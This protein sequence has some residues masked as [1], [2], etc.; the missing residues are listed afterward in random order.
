MKRRAKRA[1]I[2]MIFLLV[3]QSVV[4]GIAPI[5]M[6]YAEENKNDTFFDFESISEGSFSEED[7]GWLLHIDWSLADYDL[8]DVNQPV[9]FNSPVAL[10]EQEGTISS[11]GEE[12]E[13]ASF[14]T[15]EDIIRVTFNESALEHSEAEGTLKLQLPLE[16]E[17]EVVEREETTEEAVEEGS[18]EEGTGEAVEEEVAEE[19]G[20]EEAVEEEAAEEEEGTEEAVEEEA[21]EEE[22]TEEAVEEEAAEEEGTEEAVEEEA[23]E[24]EGTEEAVEEE[25]AEE[26][27]TEEAVEEEA[28]EEENIAPSAASEVGPQAELGNIFTFE[29]FRLDG[30]N[31]EDGHEVDF[32]GTYEVQYSWETDE[33]IQAGDTASMP[34]PDVFLHWVNTPDQPIMVE[35]TQVGTFTINDGELIFT[36]DENIEDQS[37]QNGYV[38][39]QLNF[40]REI[41]TEEWEQEIDFDGD[42]ERDLTVQVTPTEVNTDLDK[43]GR[44]DSPVN[45]KEVYWT[46]NIVNGADEAIENG[47]LAD[48][49]P[50]GLGEARDFEV[51]EIT[52]D[53]DGN[54]IVGNPIDD[55]NAPT[56]TGDGFEMT[57]DSI[58]GRSGYQVNYTTSIEDINVA[59]FTNDATFVSD[60]IDL[61]AQATVSGGERSNPIQKEGNRVDSESGDQI[62][63]TIIVNENGMSIDDARVEDQLPDGLKIVPGSINISLNGGDS[64]IEADDFPIELGQVSPDQTYTITYLT[65]INWSEVNEGEYQENNGF[66]NTAILFDGDEELNDDDATVQFDRGPILEKV[67]AGNIDYENRTV[68]WKVTV[69]KAKHLLGDVTVTDQLP[70]GLTLTNITITGENGNEF[71]GATHDEEDGLLTIDL[72]DVGTETITIEYTTSI[73]NFNNADAFTNTVGMEGDGV[74]EGGEDR[75]ATIRPHANTYQKSFDGIN[76]NEKTINWRLNVDPTRE[77]INEGFTI[78]DTFTNDG[79]ILLP[80]T[81]EITLGNENLVSGEDYTLAPIEGGYQ[82]GFTIVFN[83]EIEKA[84]L[85]VN[86]TTSYDEQFVDEDVNSLIPHSNEDEAG[87]YR[88]HA[89]FEGTTE[90]NREINEEDDASQRVI[91]NAWNS[92]F[93]EGNL[94]DSDSWSDASDR[95]IAW[96]VYFNYHQHNLGENVSVTDT[97]GY[98]GEIIEDSIT[99]SVYEVDAGGNT[100]ITDTELTL[101]DDYTVEVEG[102]ELTVNFNGEVTERYVIQFETRVPDI[103]EENYV[104]HA[105]VT[106]EEGEYPYSSS[107][108]YDRWDNVLNKEV[109][110]DVSEVYIGEELEWKITANESLSRISD[111]TL[112]DTIS[113]GLSF[114]EDSLT[115]VTSSGEEI[116][117]T[118]ETETTEDGQTILNIS[119]DEDLTEALTITYTT[120]VIAENGQTVN[121]TVDLKGKEIE[122]VTRE[123]NEIS[124][125]QFSWVGGEFRIDRGAI[126]LSKVDSA[127]EEVIKSSGATFEL[128]RVVNEER[129]L[130]GEFTTENGILEVGNLFLG[131][132]ILVEIESPN[133]YVLSDKEI[134]I[135]V[136]EPYGEN[137]IVHEVNFE[138]TKEKINVTGTKEWQGGEKHRPESIELQLSR[139]GEAV[140]NPVTLEDGETEYTWTDLDKTDIEGNE[141]NYTVDEVTVPENYEK[142]VSE[143]GLTITNEFV[144]PTTEIPVEKAWEDANNQDGNRPESV[145]VA[146]FAN[147]E[148]TDTENITLSN[149]NEW[150]GSFTDLPE[151]DNSGDKITYTVVEIDVPEQYESDIA[152]DA[153]NGFVITNSYT[154]G[155]VDIPVEKV[156]EDANNQDGAR[157]DGIT[158]RLFADGEAT[159]RFIILNET[160]NWE[161]TFAGLDEYQNG[162]RINYTVAESNVPAGYEST[163]SGST[164]NGYTI[165]NSYSPEMTDITVEKAWEDANN[166]DG[167]RPESITVHL[168]DDRSN[169]VATEEITADDDGIWSHVFENLPKYRDGVE[170]AYSVAED[171][172]EDYSTSIS[173]NGN[174][175][176]TVTNEHTPEQTSVTVN[177]FWN[178]KN[179]QDGQRPDSI[180]VQLLADGEALGNEVLITA[181]DNWSYT[182]SG[183]DANRDGGE[184][185]DYTVKEVDVT[186]GYESDI[187]DENHGAISITNSYE[188]EL[189]DIPVSKVWDDGNNQD[190]NRP[191]SITLHVIN[192][193]SEIVQTAEV[194]ADENGEWSHV[195]EGLPKFDNG[196]AIQYRITEDAIEGYGAT[197]V[198]QADGFVITNSYTPEQTSLTVTKGWDDG[199]NQDGVRPE[200]VTVQLFADGEPVNKPV[201]LSSENDWTHTWTELDVYQDGGQEIN[202]TAEET[203][204]PEG[205]EEPTVEKV[206]GNVLITNN[207][208]PDTVEIPVTKVWDDAENQDGVRPDSVTVNVINDAS[209][210]VGTAELNEENG[211]THTFE[212]LPKNRN[213][214]EIGYR[215]T[216]DSVAEY[217]TELET[218]DDGNVTVTNAYT[219]E[220]TSVTVSKGWNDNDNQDGIRPEQIEVQLYAGENE[221]GDTVILS[222]END[223]MH[224]WSELDAYQNGG[225]EINYTV[226]EV[227]VPEGYEVSVNDADHGNILLTNH[228]EPE[229][230]SVPVSK[231]WE[232]AENQD[233]I[234][235]ASITVSL[236]ADG[237]EIDSIELN[238]S[239]NWQADFTGLDKFK[240]GELIEY[241][242]E[243][244]AVD[245]Y[246]GE[247]AGNAEDGYVITNTHEPELVD[248]EGTKTWDDADNQDGKRPESITVHLLANGEEVEDAEVTEE[249]DWSYAFTDLPR[250]ENG[251]E[252]NYTIQEDNVEDYSTE[253]TG[254]DITNSYTPGKTSINVIKHWEDANNQ[255]GIRPESITV[256]LIADGEETEK[257][258]VLSADNNW[259]ADFTDLDEYN[260]GE[261]IDYTVEE[262]A[263]DGYEAETAGN[264]ENGYVITNTHEPERIDVK[265]TKTWDDNNYTDQRPDS[266]T[267]NL[268]ADGEK[269][270][271]AEVTADMDWTFEFTN[272]PK[273]AAGTEVTYTVQEAAVNGYV[274]DNV[275][276]NAADG[277]IITNRPA[278]VSVGDYVWIDV[279][280]DGLQDET[281][282][283][284]KGVVLTIEDE[285]GNPV[286]DVYGNP[287]GPV[288]TDENGYYIFENLPIDKTYIVRIDREASAEAL[289]GY[290]PTLEEAG[291]D[292]SIDSSTWFAVSRHLTEDGEHDPTLDF[293]FVKAESEEPIDPETPGEPGEEPTDPETPGEPGEEPTDPETPEEPGEEPTDPE[294]P[295]EPGEEPTDPETPGEPGEEPTEEPEAEATDSGEGTAD[296]KGKTDGD[297]VEKAGDPKVGEGAETGKGDDGE[298]L[299]GTATSMFNLLLISLG[300]LAAGAILMIVY[301]LRNRSSH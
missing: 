9:D 207:R 183:L 99:V 176:F 189:I 120:I 51:R 12:V 217:S 229:Q 75:D 150:Q 197:A 37:V 138:N 31:V 291:N 257:E 91:E 198:K 155:T 100:T 295:G 144:S 82:N 237:E 249:S 11:E 242:V 7:D 132:Y 30:E 152:G 103:S 89:H 202:Y 3:M 143:D 116:G 29:W 163:V 53:V 171:T 292:N 8:E 6:A 39:F 253:I 55:F 69:N 259:Q 102:N 243:E 194:T 187:N 36:F 188:P 215:V 251:E 219:P 161:F 244:A 47:M 221:V 139:D 52:I 206:N 204:V 286:T 19:E 15:T 178:D 156:W 182:W 235:P 34:L 287:V 245:G 61:E 145:E 180:R 72:P 21:A 68:T 131:T 105:E 209:E 277:F 87:L 94:V 160:N 159:Q 272:M 283:P 220:Q 210:I 122:T 300:L 252:I 84:E 106:T 284:L 119:F 123:T 70:E 288:T 2:F 60:N 266:I 265:G 157:P 276:G 1:S 185:I 49:I 13:I 62:E 43:S 83:R 264:A 201:R 146:L 108:H 164:E 273:F 298:T 5:Q 240:N 270:N 109:L 133:G 128:Y 124:A 141:Y 213:G 162:E 230:T 193:K 285:K 254:M 112:T 134:E 92:G 86:Y 50:N 59:Q 279:N 166:Q 71:P 48:V 117:Y 208:T 263:V 90:N 114:V 260:N 93:K 168:Y 129:V 212:D 203:N 25:E 22:G 46:V 282:I 232:D 57:F 247:T 10:I 233:G 44:T 65:E 228:H 23:A 137:E 26:E 127:T 58:D 121:N 192:G 196:K 236:L 205:Y 151:L 268:L 88:N 218:G 64:G 149:E 250:F 278:K 35:G 18:T 85:V 224:T 167:A 248:L 214:E 76:Y 113:A 200:H 170:I 267:V 246:E 110:P 147:G 179:D 54:E 111:A 153:E 148:E 177:K 256:K 81:V 281:D 130:M 154:P 226:E 38:G 95:R 115:I 191:E 135:N 172:V 104:N 14:E 241:T 173:N 290:V 234:R 42:G 238:E 136:D 67:E 293:G 158:V 223:W 78:T 275:E 299:P 211:W 186:A 199:N 107:V 16:E 41:F 28:A 289:K 165:T 45:A 118:L 73:D 225:E 271:S 280:K 66:T 140:G 77:D 301:R 239:N 184:P 80:G 79:L 262:A 175:T 63:W 20:T 261:L 195:F 96:Q 222:A 231:A 40:D 269:V 98:D 181:A 56:L 4:T 255:D 97:L 17:E 32:D 74:G 142:S 125:R 169:V 274:T 258:A 297:A 174:G 33:T 216:E 24:E 296:G 27:G 190:G 126:Q 294:T 227:S 101:N